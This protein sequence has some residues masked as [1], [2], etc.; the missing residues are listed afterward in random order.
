LHNEVAQQ[1][2]SSIAQARV[3][4]GA[5]LPNEAE[6]SLHF[7]VSRTVLR[8]AVKVIASKG[9]VEIKRK[10]GTRARPRGDW[11][12]LAPQ[13][14]GWF[15][16]GLDVSEG[17]ADLLEGRR[18][19]EPQ[20]AA[21]AAERATSLDLEMIE[22]ACRGMTV[23]TRDLHASVAADLQ[24]HLAILEATHNIFMLPFGAMIQAALAQSFR[25]TSQD[26]PA[27]FRSLLLHQAVVSAIRHR[28]SYSAMPAMLAMLD[29]TSADIAHRLTSITQPRAKKG[30]RTR[31]AKKVKA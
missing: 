3:P 12:M 19:I 20:A 1:L 14:L 7:N 26:R 11:N 30:R 13:V 5:T 22:A 10:T 28:D 8:E 29:Q 24:F 6:L 18:Q 27:Y 16:S 4:P 31:P 2:G 17:L 15:F 21:L 23:A 25:L 9:L